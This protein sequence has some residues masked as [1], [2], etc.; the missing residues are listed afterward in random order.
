MLN[1]PA[2]LAVAGMTL[3]W[4]VEA[5]ERVALPWCLPET[6]NRPVGLEASACPGRP[7]SHSERCERTLLPGQGSWW[8]PSPA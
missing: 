3:F 5:V 2:S 7:A 1:G 6:E 4:A 8:T